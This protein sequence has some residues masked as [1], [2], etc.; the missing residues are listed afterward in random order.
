M[1]RQEFA[2][3]VQDLVNQAYLHD[4]DHK[5]YKGLIHEAEKLREPATLADV[6][7]WEVRVLYE[8]LN[9]FTYRLKEPNELQEYHD[10]IET[11]SYLE[12]GW[13]NYTID[14]LRNAKKVEDKKY[15]AKIK[16]WEKVSESESYYWTLAECRNNLFISYKTEEP[17][18][19]TKF[20]KEEWAELG[21]TDENAD[22]E[23][24][25]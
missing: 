7:G 8:D 18:Y 20:T 5:Y 17:N 16:G 12:L 21:I 1:N 2:T 24:V 3:R 19:M 6:L 22:F 4:V 15:Y 25:K 10:E 14:L 9:G 11:W 23:E 13:S